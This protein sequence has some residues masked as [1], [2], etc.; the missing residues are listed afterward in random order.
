MGKKFPYKAKK[1]KL[2]E[3]LIQLSKKNAKTLLK[4]I[5]KHVKKGSVIYSDCWSG[6][7]RLEQCGFSHYTVNH[8]EHFKDPLTGVCTNTIEGNW[9]SIKDLIPIQMR[10]KDIID[11]KLIEY[12]W[13]RKYSNNVWIEFI[14]C[15]KN[16][17]VD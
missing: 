12:M 5:K 3:S 17:F 13:R 15:M 16:C 8:S 4:V 7:Y 1:R 11:E 6:Y 9:R 2:Y 10:S 14:N